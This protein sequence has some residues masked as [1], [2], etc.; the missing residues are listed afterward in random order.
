MAFLHD[1]SPDNAQA[2]S[3]GWMNYSD[4]GVKAGGPRGALLH[5]GEWADAA[6]LFH[7]RFG[8]AQHRGPVR[9]RHEFPRVGDLIRRVAGL[10]AGL[11]R[12]N[13]AEA[14]AAQPSAATRSATER[15]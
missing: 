15:M 13:R 5:N 6:E 3:G 12:S 4:P 2:S 8:V 9:I 10:E 11:G 14:T 7:G 1:R